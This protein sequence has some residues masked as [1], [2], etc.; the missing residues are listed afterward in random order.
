MISIFV[1]LFYTKD[2]VEL[3]LHHLW[4]V[5]QQSGAEEETI[6][7]ILLLDSFLSFFFLSC[8]ITEW[9]LRGPWD[10]VVLFT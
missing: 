4:G 9:S 7:T 8:F 6:E 5:L 10:N 1:D 2:T 3:S